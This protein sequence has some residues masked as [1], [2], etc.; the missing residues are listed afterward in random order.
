MTVRLRSLPG[1]PWSGTRT[2]RS[3]PVRPDVFQYS[4]QSALSVLSACD[5]H[6][7]ISN[8]QFFEILLDPECSL[9]ASQQQPAASK[10]G[11]VD[12]PQNVQFRICIEIN[13]DIAAKHEIKRSERTHTSA[14]VNGLKTD[15]T[16]HLIAQM[17]VRAGATKMLNQQSCRKAPVHLD[18]LILSGSGA[19]DN[20]RGEVGTQNL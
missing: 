4:M 2:P 11:A 12:F 16:P 9:S 20:L 8:C 5:V 15:H 17:P 14:Q 13:H 19:F 18:L 7:C 3:A 10:Q 6:S 1:T